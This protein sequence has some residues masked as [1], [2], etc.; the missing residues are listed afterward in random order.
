MEQLALDRAGV[1]HADHHLRQQVLE[2]ARRREVV[3]RPDLA[4]I[5]HHRIARFRAIDGEAGHQRLG[6]GEQVVANPGHR[7]IRENVVGIAE[8]I[9]LDAAAREAMKALCVWQTPFGLP[10]VPEV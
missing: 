4:Q 5:G 1:F 2:H 9:E 7:Q 8:A 3:G 6:E 10:V